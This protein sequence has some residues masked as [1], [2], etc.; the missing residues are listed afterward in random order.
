VEDLGLPGYAGSLDLQ[1][2]L[3]T[4]ANPEDRLFASPGATKR[5]GLGIVIR[6]SGA[7]R[8][9]DQVG[10]LTGSLLDFAPVTNQYFVKLSKKMLE[11]S[12]EGILVVD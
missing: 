1:D 8:K 5:L 10:G 6:V 3:K 4:K 12:G 2:E 9:Y 11:V 7:G